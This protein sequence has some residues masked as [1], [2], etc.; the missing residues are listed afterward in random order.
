MACL[1]VNI[2]LINELEV[3]V[4]NDCWEGSFNKIFWNDLENISAL[5]HLG[6][7]ELYV[8]AN[9]SSRANFK[10][11]DGKISAGF[12][13]VSD[14]EN[15]VVSELTKEV[16]Y[17]LQ[18][19]VSRNDKQDFFSEDFLV[20]QSKI[21]V[22]TPLI[23]SFI[24]RNKGKR[25][26]QPVVV[27]VGDK[28]FIVSKKFRSLA[29]DIKYLEPKTI[30]GVLDGIIISKNQ[31]II[32]DDNKNKIPVYFTF[33]RYFNELHHLHGSTGYINFDVRPVLNKQNKIDYF[34]QGFNL[35]NPEDY[36]D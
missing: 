26:R 25:L 24:D 28:K 36:F 19:V 18:S 13:I 23:I 3:I 32:I 17:L 5:I 9:I 21:E 11:S 4:H 35:C 31:L 20:D 1:N 10:L 6:L 12:D 30:V 29:K 8:D 27:I 22:L 14:C 15:I 2:N 16:F 33:E 34:I 7:Q